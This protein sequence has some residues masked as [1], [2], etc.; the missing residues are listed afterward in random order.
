MNEN[1][2]LGYNRRDFLKG[3]SL[4][5]VMTMLGGVELLGQTNQ[6][7]SGESK[8]EKVKMQ[9]AVTRLGTRGRKIINPLALLDQAEGAAICDPSPAALKR[10]ASAAPAATQ[11]DD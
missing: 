8:S 3:G 5:T 9:G 11:T 4:A 6:P 1:D 2:A 10:I 7:S